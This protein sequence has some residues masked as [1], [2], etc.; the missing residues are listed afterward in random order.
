MGC[1]LTILMDSQII[2]DLA[3]KGEILQFSLNEWHLKG[4]KLKQKIAMAFFTSHSGD[5]DSGQSHPGSDKWLFNG[6][7]RSVSTKF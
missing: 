7:C 4:L 3:G 6:A 1:Y 5:R 2:T